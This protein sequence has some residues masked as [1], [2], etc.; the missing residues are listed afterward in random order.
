MMQKV[1]DQENDD[2]PQSKDN[3]YDEVKSFLL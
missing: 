2:V 1:K 3:I